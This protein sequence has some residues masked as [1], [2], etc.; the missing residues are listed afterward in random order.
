[1]RYAYNA[2]M[3]GKMFIKFLISN[4][5]GFSEIKVLPLTVVFASIAYFAMAGIL[6][7]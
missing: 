6:F 3:I 4:R 1:M 5:N 2:S 7:F